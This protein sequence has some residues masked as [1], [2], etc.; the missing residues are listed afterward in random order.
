MYCD[1]KK[2]EAAAA[3]VQCTVTQKSEKQ[4]LQE[5]IYNQRP[6][7]LDLEIAFTV[8]RQNKKIPLRIDL[9]RLNA[10]NGVQL[11][12]VEA[13]RVTDTR[14]RAEHMEP[15]IFGQMTD[16]ARFLKSAKNN[17][18]ESYQGI[19]S[20]YLENFNYLFSFK[21]HEDLLNSF[22]AEAKRVILPPT[23]LLLSDEQE[24]KKALRGARGKNGGDHYKTLKD[25]FD[26]KGWILETLP[27]QV[28]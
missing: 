20:N 3:A 5:Y 6:C 26:E 14:L 28:D 16:Y 10:D 11:Q 2:R 18:L 24:A 8:E 4:L 23:L 15:E 25:K 22:R 21:E 1:I 27:S 13:K 19:C 17:I 9:V 7:L 12:F